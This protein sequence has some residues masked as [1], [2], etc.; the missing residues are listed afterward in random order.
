MSTQHHVLSHV[1]RLLVLLLVLLTGSAG[2]AVA[3]GTTTVSLTLDASPPWT[4]EVPQ[5]IVPASTPGQLLSDGDRFV[6]VLA[7]EIDNGAQQRLDALA[8]LGAADDS[9]ESVDAGDT[10]SL[11][12][13]LD[14]ALVDGQPW[15]AFTVVRTEADSGTQVFTMYAAPVE[16][17]ADGLA[18]AQES[19]TVNGE[20]VFDGVGGEGL[21]ELLVAA[22][23]AATDDGEG[24]DEATP[25]PSEDDEPA[26]DPTEEPGADDGDKF[27][28]RD[29]E[30]LPYADVGMVGPREYVS[31]QFGVE[32]EWTSDWALD[33]DFG[34]AVLSDPKIGVDLVSLLWNEERN[35][36]LSIFMVS[37]GDLTVDGIAANAAEN[38]RN[39]F[40]EDAS[41]VM[42]NGSSGLG[43]AVILID[44]GRGDPT[45]VYEEYRLSADGQ[46]LVVVSLF[47]IDADVTE[48]G[49]E[50]ATASITIDGEPVLIYYP[51]ADVADVHAG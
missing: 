17:F 7:G 41:V 21:E 43:A 44:E 1:S 49:I 16:G 18:S 11:A 25:A 47:S 48:A 6:L 31:P 37:R 46:A 38:A 24:T 22:A 20:P 14:V 50:S 4:E 42:A 23:P 33:E 19:I 36:W 12:Y 40:G 35:A 15:G 51:A 13:W 2:V 34:D 10:E 32:V 5:D 8:E 3:Q 28:P 29:N 45:L 39:N 9:I 26:A 27:A 30:D